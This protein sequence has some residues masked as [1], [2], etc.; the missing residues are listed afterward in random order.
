MTPMLVASTAGKDAI[1]GRLWEGVGEHLPLDR[2][3]FD[4]ETALLDALA[5]L[6]GG[7]DFQRVVVD[8][9][10]RRM[11]SG[12]K[13]LRGIERLVVFDHD[14]CQEYV[15]SGD[16]YRRYVPVL[17]YIGAARTLVSSVSLAAHLERHGLD[18]V[19]LPK[20]QNDRVIRDLGV[21]RDIEAAF[22]GRMSHRVYRDRKRLLEAVRQAEGLALM[23]TEPGDAYNAALNRI[24][25]FVSADVGF[26]EYMIKNFEAMAAGCALLAWRQPDCE[27]Q[28]LG[29]NDGEHLMLFSSKHELIDKLRALKA[30][31]SRARALATAGQALVRARH[32]WQHRVAPLVEMLQRPLTTPSARLG[33]AERARLLRL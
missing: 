20:A 7:H 18:A 3:L 2:R 6:A 1:C 33:L 22:V 16:W 21:T 4:N 14:I 10:L 23:R 15:R 31:P 12:V 32:G 26:N 25:V 8:A 11:G 17:K 29:L 19:F 9:N 24:G 13:R 30:D 28:A 27:Q 5:P